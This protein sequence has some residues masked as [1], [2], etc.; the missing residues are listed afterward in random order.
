M[1]LVSTMLTHI[2]FHSKCKIRI[3][4]KWNIGFLT[5]TKVILL[6]NLNPINNQALNKMNIVLIVII[7]KAK[8]FILM[9]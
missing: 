8:I 4:L 1:N 2:I 3:L 9:T 6:N 5:Q 7:V